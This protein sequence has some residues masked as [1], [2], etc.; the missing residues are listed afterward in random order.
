M[1]SGG[2]EQVL[3][4]EPDVEL[5]AR[6][7]HQSGKIIDYAVILVV[8]YD[9]TVRTV[10]V[11]DGAHGVNDLHRYTRRGGKQRAESFHSGTLGEG[12]RSAVEAVKSGYREMVFAWQA[13]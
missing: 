8:T 1:R 3:N 7:T 12:M 10:R 11:Y 4:H 2:W 6:Y 9:A 5:I 13:S